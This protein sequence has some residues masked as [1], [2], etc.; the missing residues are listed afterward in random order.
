MQFFDVF[1]VE[2]F[3]WLYFCFDA[4]LK[5]L[6]D[7]P[8]QGKK[9]LRGREFPKKSRF[10]RSRIYSIKMLKIY[11]IFYCLC[12]LVILHECCLLV[13][14]DIFMESLNLFELSQNANEIVD[15]LFLG[16]VEAALDSVWLERN[17]ITRVISICNF[18]VVVQFFCKRNF[19]RGSKV[20][21]FSEIY[22][23]L[24]E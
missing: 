13:Y 5:H 15:Y 2:C 3:R 23:V 16:N 19:L 9:F 24:S 20:E 17:G 22:K 6:F 8:Q 10:H 21:A 11:N 14:I 7:Q 4:T 18:S 12:I 1:R